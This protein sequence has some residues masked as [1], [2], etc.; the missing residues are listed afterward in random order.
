V[1]ED[2]VQFHSKDGCVYMFVQKDK[3]W[4]KFCP[5]KELPLDV[6]RQISELK[7]KADILGDAV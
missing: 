1:A 5:V 3:Q 7:E 6:K 4:Y 2:T